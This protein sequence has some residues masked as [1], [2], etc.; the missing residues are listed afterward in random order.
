MKREKLLERAKQCV[1]EMYNAAEN[2]YGRKFNFNSLQEITEHCGTYTDK[3][4]RT[5]R[6]LP[7]DAFYLPEATQ[8][9]ILEKYTK[10]LRSTWYFPYKLGVSEQYDDLFEVFA[11]AF[12]DAV[13]AAK[14]NN[15]GAVGDLTPMLEHAIDETNRHAAEKYDPMFRDTMGKLFSDECRRRDFTNHTLNTYASVTVAYGSDAELQEENFMHFNE[16]WKSN[17]VD[18]RFHLYM[19]TLEKLQ[20]QLDTKVINRSTYNKLVADLAK[21]YGCTR[22]SWDKEKIQW[23]VLDYAPTSSDMFYGLV[24][25]AYQRYKEMVKDDYDET[26]VKQLLK[27]CAEKCGIEHYGEDHFV[28]QLRWIYEFEKTFEE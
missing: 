1:V 4:G 3:T 2:V 13:R 18:A 23:F 20:L 5:S 15:N 8:R 6:M 28:E 26:S 22:R 19:E 17:S 24:K 9:A 25:T 7:F 11:T 12:D 14:E 10:G 21:Q 27:E 16:M